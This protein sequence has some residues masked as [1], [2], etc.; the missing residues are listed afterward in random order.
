MDG[1]RDASSRGMTYTPVVVDERDKDSS[2]P[3]SSLGDYT[4]RE[5]AEKELAE[6]LKTEHGQYIIKSWI[7]ERL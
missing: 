4:T 5:Q 7:E 2:E 3:E 1:T 6:Y